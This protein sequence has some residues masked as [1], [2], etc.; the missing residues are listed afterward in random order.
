MSILKKKIHSANL[1]WAVC[2]VSIRLGMF[3]VN[4]SNKAIQVNEETKMLTVWSEVL[5]RYYL[6]LFLAVT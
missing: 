2:D 4:V 1:T 3:T 6:H 5:F